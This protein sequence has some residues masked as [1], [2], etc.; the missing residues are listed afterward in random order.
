MPDPPDPDP[1]ELDYR[2]ILRRAELAR[3]YNTVD[4]EN[5][6]RDINLLT[7]IVMYKLHEERRRKSV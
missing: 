2:D 6:L 1:D 7:Q 3:L 4:V 5:I